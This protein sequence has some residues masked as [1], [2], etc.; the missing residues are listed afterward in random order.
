MHHLG[1]QC[2]IKSLAYDKKQ[3]MNKLITLCHICHLN[4]PSV[5]EKMSAKAKITGKNIRKNKL[6]QEQSLSKE[7]IVI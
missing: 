5:R 7:K 4:L 6:L 1:E 2:G 3:D